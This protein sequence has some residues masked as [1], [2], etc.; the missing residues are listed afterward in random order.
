MNKQTRIQTKRRVYM[1]TFGI[2]S[3]K[4]RDLP[5][6]QQFV[7]HEVFEQRAYIRSPDSLADDV[8]L[9]VRVGIRRRQ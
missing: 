2:G 8:G 5:C 7:P 3:H 1:Y 6:A 4:N 9:A